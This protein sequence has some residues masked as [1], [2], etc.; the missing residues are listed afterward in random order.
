MVRTIASQKDGEV[1]TN[2]KTFPIY[3]NHVLQAPDGAPIARI[4]SHRSEW[5]L[6]RGLA[7]IVC[8][9][10][11]TIRLRFEPKGRGNQGDTYYL[12]DKENK[13]VVCGKEDEINKHHV[14][15]RVYRR[16][17]PDRYK[18]RTSHDVVVLCLDCHAKYETLA[19]KR[20]AAIA[21]SLGYTSAC[22]KVRDLPEE[23]RKE[24]FARKA[25]FA[26]FKYGTSIPPERKA[27]LEA[28][29]RDHVG[30]VPLDDDLLESIIH[31]QV[32]YSTGYLGNEMARYVLGRVDIDDF[33]LGWRQHF[34][35]TMQPQYLPTG[36]SVEY[37]TSKTN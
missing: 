35:E 36:W 24:L 3:S 32:H 9:S 14:V 1:P 7:D 27:R 22:P 28:T 11:Y 10:P 13:C 26:L 33:C 19:D 18:N 30:S 4:G 2:A 34:V 31:S 29:V 37:P 6:Q 5:Y 25:A 21:I 17:M 16:Q 12:S 15:P 8:E 20:K 23:K